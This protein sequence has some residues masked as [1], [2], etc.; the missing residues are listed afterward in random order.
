MRKSI[1]FIVTAV[2]A[3]VLLAFTFHYPYFDIYER[4]VLIALS[5]L[6]AWI[7]VA[8]FTLKKTNGLLY[9][10]I[11]AV[12][13]IL[14]LFARERHG[15]EA[16]IGPFL[17]LDEYFRVHEYVPGFALFNLIGNSVVFAPMGIIMGKMSV[18]VKFRLLGLLCVVALVIPLVELLQLVFQVGWFDYY[19]WI[20][21]GISAI[22]GF[23]YACIV[24]RKE[25]SV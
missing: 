4:P 5:F 8:T 7:L 16:E 9:A 15:V 24:Y 1:R 22:L 25:R 20:F 11:Y 19:D 10:V 6:G 21:N 3:V 17:P 2:C 12:A 23:L 13:L 14:L 18:S